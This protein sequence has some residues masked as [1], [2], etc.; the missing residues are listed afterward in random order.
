MKPFSVITLRWSIESRMPRL[1]R[2]TVECSRTCT[3]SI[4]F[5]YS[6]FGSYLCT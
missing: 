5:G 3:C 1:S 6:R 2:S 4:R